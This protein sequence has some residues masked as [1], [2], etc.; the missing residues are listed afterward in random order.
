MAM[1]RLLAL[2]S[3]VCFS[4]QE[5][6]SLSFTAAS[7]AARKATGFSEWRDRLVIDEDRR[8]ILNSELLA[9][10]PV[11]LNFGFHLFAPRVLLKR[12]RFSPIIPA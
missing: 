9:S 11:G 3:R 8:S 7:I 6:L 5:P 2:K 12:S 4:F 1:Y 10:F